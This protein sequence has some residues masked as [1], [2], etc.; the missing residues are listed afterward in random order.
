MEYVHII[1]T[2]EHFL[3]FHEI[4]VVDVFWEAQL[5]SMFRPKC[6]YLN[7]RTDSGIISWFSSTSDFD[8]VITCQIPVLFCKPP[9]RFPLFLFID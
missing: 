2:F 5:S 8:L 1:W 4:Y 3:I 7:D 6:D 9:T